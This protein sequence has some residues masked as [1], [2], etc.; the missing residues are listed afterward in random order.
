[1]KAYRERNASPDYLRLVPDL[2]EDEAVGAQVAD[3]PFDAN[4]FLTPH[5]L[6]LTR[7]V[8]AVSRNYA[9]LKPESMVGVV[10]EL[11][12]SYEAPAVEADKVSKSKVAAVTSIFVGGFSILSLL[13]QISYGVTVLHPAICIPSIIASVTFYIMSKMKS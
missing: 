10:K 4:L 1:M 6:T 11:Q 12:T 5:G 7:G 3:A 8:G 13:I 9:F 2:D